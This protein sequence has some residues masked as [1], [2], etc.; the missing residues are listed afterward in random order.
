MLA[1]LGAIAIEG[2]DTNLGF[3]Q[4]VIGHPAFRAGDVRTGFVDRFKK[5]LL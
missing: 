2:V 1:T 4:K 5:E 3:L